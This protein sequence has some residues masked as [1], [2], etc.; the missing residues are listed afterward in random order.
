MFFFVIFSL[1]VDILF[2][3]ATE[4]RAYALRSYIVQVRTNHLSESYFVYLPIL[5][6]GLCVAFLLFSFQFQTNQMHVWYSSGTQIYVI[7]ILN[8]S[9]PEHFCV[10]ACVCVCICLAQW[11][12]LLS[13]LIWPM[14]RWTIFTQNSSQS[15]R[16]RIPSLYWNCCFIENAQFYW[17]CVYTSGSIFKRSLLEKIH[18]KFM[19]CINNPTLDNIVPA[20]IHQF[21]CNITNK[22]CIQTTA[23]PVTI[24]KHPLLFI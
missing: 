19:K 9:G 24:Q 1:D 6:A 20:H 22:C 13:E 11:M 8:N 3:W 21:T 18:R 12:L 10:C 4:V 23:N 2:E 7:K 16:K 17:R 5:R 14:C 15:I